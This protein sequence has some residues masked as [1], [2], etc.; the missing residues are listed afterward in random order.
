MSIVLVTGAA[1]LIG[2]EAVRFF[3]GRGFKV[4]GIDNDMRRY[5]FGDEGSS[6]GNLV[7]LA[8]HCPGFINHEADIRDR[9]ALENLF[10][11][12]NTDI[13]LVIHCAAQPGHNWAAREP[14]TDFD[15]NAVG[16]ANLLEAV[17]LHCPKAVFILTSTNKVYGDNVN[18]LP[19]VELPTRWELDAGHPY[20]AKGVDETMSL[21]RCMH[22]LFGASKLAGD[23][24]AQEYGRY[25]GIRT[26]V[27]RG[28][29]L[30]GPGHAG[31]E[32]HGFL[33]YLM[34]CA[35]LG[36]QYKI[37][38]YGGK[39]VRDNIHSH[40]LVG[41]FDQFFQAPRAGEV[42][43]I[44]GSR[45]SHCSLL[46]AAALCDTITGKRLDTV[47]VDEP[48]AGD[49]IWWVS[50]VSKFATHYP[51][52]KLTRTVEDILVEIYQENRERWLKT[53]LI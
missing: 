44:G 3:S 17:R 21:D 39:Q 12:Y 4:V 53:P 45:F 2:A 30:S 42:Y 49:H 5:F 32:G 36:R 38:G 52:W 15:V 50:D 22:S 47:L 24:L 51:A 29:C 11:E 43:N 48:R 37:F 25:F 28:G 16:T 23:V 13:A 31:V 19:F 8:E 14:L 6:H 1:G 26:G 35:V 41:A 9:P 10:R 34:K 27:F 46:E 33:A 18:R 20:A 40:D 7:R